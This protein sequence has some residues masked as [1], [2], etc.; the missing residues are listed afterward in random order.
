MLKKI[1]YVSLFWGFL[2]FF[3]ACKGCFSSKTPTE[4]YQT[5][6][7]SLAHY[8][9]E[10]PFK[11]FFFADS[12]DN[13]YEK[14]NIGLQTDE[15]AQK[16]SRQRSQMLQ[17]QI[18]WIPGSLNFLVRNNVQNPDSTQYL[19]DYLFGKIDRMQV[20]SERAEDLRKYRD[21]LSIFKQTLENDRNEYTSLLS[22]TNALRRATERIAA[23]NRFINTFPQNLHLQQVKKLRGDFVIDMCNEYLAQSPRDLKFFDDALLQA[24]RE[25]NMLVTNL[26]DSAYNYF[27]EMLKDKQ[28]TFVVQLCRSGEGASES[29]IVDNSALNKLH[30]QVQYCQTLRKKLYNDSY[31]AELQTIIQQKQGSADSAAIEYLQQL[32]A[33]PSDQLV[34]INQSLKDADVVIAKMY[35]SDN[36]NSAKTA[37]NEL[38]QK[39]EKWVISDCQKRLEKAAG[40]NLV[41]L[42]KEIGE[43]RKNQQSLMTKGSVLYQQCDKCVAEMENMRSKILTKLGDEAIFKVKQEFKEECIK[44]LEKEYNICKNLS[45]FTDFL[46]EKLDKGESQNISNGTKQLFKQTYEINVKNGVGC[47]KS[48]HTAFVEFNLFLENDKG[49]STVVLTKSLPKKSK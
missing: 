14:N 26:Q 33:T 23:T 30:A 49:V 38:A 48:K 1:L 39:R 9:P 17:N 37:V 42:N 10:N 32:V 24:E 35:G 25:K 11:R 45:D 20:F 16:L 46:S 21:Q 22:E 6:L 5:G 43:V 47:N 34:F 41:A 19:I 2:L 29:K 44:F 15:A 8:N 18:D 7:D 13:F 4:E 40:L 27:V 12:L 31:A 3:P 36:K 28:G